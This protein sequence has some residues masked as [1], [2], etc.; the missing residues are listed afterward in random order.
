MI[1]IFGG[2]VDPV[3]AYVCDRLLARDIDFLL[4]DARQYPHQF[5]L[6]CWLNDG[7]IAGSIRYGNREVPLSEV[8]SVFVR[9][10]TKP[11]WLL[12]I[13]ANTLS[14]LVVNRPFASASNGSKPYQQQIIQRHGF[15]VPR[16]LVT[17]IPEAARRF[18]EE[19]Y[20]RVIY[21]SVSS[22]RS[23][24]KRMKAEDLEQLE[25]VRN[26]P[27]QFQEYIPGVDIRVHTVGSEI[28]A[29]EISSEATDYRYAKKEDN[30]VM[31]GI[32]LPA[33]IA[34]RCLELTKGLG[35]AM[36]GIDLRKS[37]AGEYYCFEVNPSP[38]FTFYQSHAQQRI[39]DALVRLLCEGA[40]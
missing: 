11:C 26:C 24:V 8:R 7:A 2:L 36:G 23:I 34:Q 33:E 20:S 13:L 38:A 18:Y 5:E 6:D 27:T 15:K 4:L 40:A 32:E 1:L 37:P 3:E 28:F 9:Q 31:R 19:C 25:L 12:H 35:L 39:G 30:R 29:T 10:I 14:A 21:K 16:T 22:V 17:T